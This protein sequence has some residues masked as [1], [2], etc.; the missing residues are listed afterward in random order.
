MYGLPDH[1]TFSIVACD[2]ERT[3]WGVA[4]STKPASVGAIV[5]WAAWRVG[6]LATQAM[7]NYDYGSRGL[8]LLRR[9][10]DAESVVRKLTRADPRRLHRQLAVVDRRG[11][12]AAWTGAKCI[13][14]ALHHVGDGFSC[15]GNMLASAAV[16]PAM[17]RAFE[18]TR[19]SLAQRMLA[20]L[21]A[22]AAKG[23][24]KRGMES[25]ALIVVHREPWLPPGSGDRWV[26]VRVDRHPRP[27]RELA[28]LVRADEAETRKYLAQRAAAARKRRAKAR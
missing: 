1:G 17:A 11:R 3:F 18:S 20:A 21:V 23:G 8:E 13:E 19:G 7:A 2:P 5:P 24:D 4:V 16:V 14:H 15:Q 22:G 6:G 27:I 9:G 25:A 26:D 10:V 12:A 28:R